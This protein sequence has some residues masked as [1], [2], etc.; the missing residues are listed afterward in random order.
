VEEK[1]RTLMDKEGEPRTPSQS[2]LEEGEDAEN[3]NKECCESNNHVIIK[4]RH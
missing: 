3:T 4:S 2:T 1:E